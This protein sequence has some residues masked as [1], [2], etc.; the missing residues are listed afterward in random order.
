MGLLEQTLSDI[1]HDLLV[2]SDFGG[3]AH[4]GAQFGRQVDVLSFLSDFEQWL[5][6]GVDFHL[7]GRVK[8]VDHVGSGL[9]VAVVE[10]V[11]LGVHVPLDGVH[12]VG[13]VGPVL[14]HNDCS[15]E[16][17]VDEALVVALLSVLN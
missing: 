9:L 2:L 14:G 4:K 8:I 13:S 11:V 1:G 15:L 16:F 5:I 7:I 12:L 17:S 10:D 3:D 6:Y